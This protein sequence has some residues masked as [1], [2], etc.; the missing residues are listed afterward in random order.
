MFRPRVAV[1]VMVVAALILFGCGGGS[2]EK[3]KSEPKA[4]ATAS[5]SAGDA[6]PTAG[7]PSRSGSFTTK[8]IDC[9]KLPAPAGFKLDPSYKE[10]CLFSKPNHESVSAEFRPDEFVDSGRFK[11][12]LKKSG[13]DVDGW[14]YAIQSSMIDA[15]LFTRFLVTADSVILE[16]SV[17]GA[18]NDPTV[19]ETTHADFCDS[20]KRQVYKE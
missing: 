12:A 20:V 13:V 10:G 16:C 15:S 2:S 5:E 17:I 19:D 7:T 4:S 6:S 14:N 1:G 8:R 9:K 11:S 3:P 18:P